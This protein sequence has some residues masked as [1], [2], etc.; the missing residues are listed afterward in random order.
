MAGM[1][2]GLLAEVRLGTERVE[3]EGSCIILSFARQGT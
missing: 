1:E 3:L 2:G